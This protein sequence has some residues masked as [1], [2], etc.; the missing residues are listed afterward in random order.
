MFT[1]S[2]LNFVGLLLGDTFLGLKERFEIA[3]IH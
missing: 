3:T 2:L 1:Q